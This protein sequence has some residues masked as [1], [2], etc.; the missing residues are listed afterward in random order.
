MADVLTSTGSVASWTP[1]ASLGIAVKYQKLRIQLADMPAGLVYSVPSWGTTIP[2]GSI[3]LG[4][5]AYL[6][7]DMDV[8]ASGIT[9]VNLAFGVAGAALAEPF[10]VSADKNIF[11]ETSGPLSAFQNP[12][13]DQIPGVGTNGIPMTAYTSLTAVGANLDQLV[14]IDL[15]IMLYYVEAGITFP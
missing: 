13:A 1:E 11:A 8:G 14:A 2:V 5:A 10:P 9:E 12:S 3:F 7:E 4:G 15:S 6:N